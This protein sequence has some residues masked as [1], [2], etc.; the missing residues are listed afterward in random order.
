VLEAYLDKRSRSGGQRAVQDGTLKPGDYVVAGQAW[1]RV[2][3]MT[4]DRGRIS[5]RRGPGDAGRGPRSLR[6]A[7]RWRHDLR[8][9]RT[10]RRRRRSPSSYKKAERRSS[11]AQM[12]GVRGLEEFTEDDAGAASVEELRLIIKATC[13]AR[14]RRSSRRSRSCRPTRSRSTSS[15]AASVASPR[16]TSCSRPASRR[17]SSASTCARPGKAAAIAKKERRRRPQLLHHL[18]GGRRREA[19]RW[20]KLLAPTTSRRSSARP[21]S[22]WSSPSRRSGTIAGSMVTGR[23]DPAHRQGAPGPRL[24]RSSSAASQPLSVATRTT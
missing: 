6:P 1:G 20:R 15:T 10:R 22:A 2:R 9:S 7:Q 21:R 12:T 18:R 19:R 11:R 23:Q 17:S 24:A 3:A 14:S 16:T 8:R 5:R 4:D 13:R